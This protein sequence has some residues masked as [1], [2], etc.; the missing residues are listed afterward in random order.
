MESKVMKVVISSSP[1]PYKRRAWI[2]CTLYI[3]YRVLMTSTINWSWNWQS[4]PPPA[5]KTAFTVDRC[6][7]AAAMCKGVAPYLERNINMTIWPNW[8][9]DQVDHLTKLTIWPSWPFDQ[10]D[11]LDQID[12]LKTEKRWNHRYL[13]AP[14][15]S[16]RP[17]SLL[18]QEAAPL[19]TCV[20]GNN[21]KNK[22]FSCSHIDVKHQQQWN[23]HKHL[24]QGSPS[25]GVCVLYICPSWDQKRHHTI[26]AIGWGHL[27]E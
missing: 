17:R 24:V 19:L 25:T 11:H 20:R 13:E 16:W 21:P 26:L 9:F 14:T 27:R 22:T 15:Y 4:S 7:A 18:Q 10:N 2:G 23:N 1:R 3:Q 5:S 12:H 8:S 6:P